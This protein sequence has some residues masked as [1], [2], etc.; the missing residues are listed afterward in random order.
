MLGKA[1]HGFSS[2]AT[3]YDGLTPWP[4]HPRFLWPFW[5]EHRLWIGIPPPPAWIAIAFH[6]ICDSS[7]CETLSYPAR[8]PLC[9]IQ[10]CPGS[11]CECSRLVAVC[12]VLFYGCP[13]L[14]YVLAMFAFHCP[15]KDVF[16]SQLLLVFMAYYDF[17][18][19]TI[20]ENLLPFT[21]S[22]VHQ[23]LSKYITVCLSVVVCFCL[24]WFIAVSCSSLDL[25]TVH[26]NVLYFLMAY[27]EKSESALAYCSSLLTVL[28]IV[29]HYN[30]TY[31][32]V[33][34]HWHWLHGICTKHLW[35]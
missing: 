3:V 32:D 30:Y 12:H 25:F 14:C 9:F 5:F 21:G 10:I 27:S 29:Y 8:S 24:S 33:H 7:L 13:W 16:A 15:P 17:V 20:Y 35:L 4:F 28:L 23:S 19:I 6:T 2:L 1:H 11:A 31:T 18:R 26:H 34:F 22:P